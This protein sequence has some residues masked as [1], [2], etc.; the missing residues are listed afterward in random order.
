MAA[1]CA[2]YR[3]LYPYV[4]ETVAGRRLTVIVPRLSFGPSAVTHSLP[5]WWGLGGTAFSFH[6]VCIFNLFC[7]LFPALL[8]FSY[9]IYV[10]IFC[11]SGFFS[12]SDSFENYMFFFCSL[13]GYPKISMCRFTLSEYSTNH[14]L[15]S[16]LEH[17]SVNTV[18][19]WPS[20]LTCCCSH[21]VSFYPV[22]FSL[23]M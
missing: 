9:S 20:Q 11:H 16:A 1:C 15:C 2:S 12:S 17:R 19:P 23:F 4:T 3:E 6:F 7:F 18:A 22:S 8:A 5:L 21:A 10:F 14:R 13:S